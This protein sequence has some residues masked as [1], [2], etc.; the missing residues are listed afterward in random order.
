M[1]HVGII[2]FGQF[3]QLAAQHLQ[4][5]L[6]VTVTDF[7]DRR[8][9]AHRLG[10]TWGGLADVCQCEVIVLA[11]PAVAM[12]EVLMAMAPMLRAGTVVVGTTC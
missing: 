3:G 5:H 6:R 10:V 2:G 1:K 8:E 11:V 4:A 7:E 9:A 12:R